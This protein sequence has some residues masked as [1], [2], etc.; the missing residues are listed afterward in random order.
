LNSFIGEV[1]HKIVCFLFSF[2]CV[3]SLF[4]DENDSRADSAGYDEQEVSYYC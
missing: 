3:F 2:K 4:A 1:R